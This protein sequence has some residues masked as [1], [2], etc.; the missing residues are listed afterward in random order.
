MSASSAAA[1]RFAADFFANRNSEARSPRFGPAN[2]A[3][4]SPRKIAA[5]SQ[6]FSVVCTMSAHL[7]ETTGYQ[8]ACFQPHPHSFPARPLFSANC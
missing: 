5:I 7:I 8:N 3:A 6:L 1:I 2:D 4:Y